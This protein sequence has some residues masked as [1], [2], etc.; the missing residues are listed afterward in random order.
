[1]AVGSLQ[2]GPRIELCPIKGPRR[3]VVPGLALKFGNAFT[4]WASTQHKG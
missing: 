3:A 1:V 4:Q 2:P